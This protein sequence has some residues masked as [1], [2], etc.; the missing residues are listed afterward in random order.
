MDFIGNLSYVSNKIEN[1]IYIYL[2]KIQ[3]LCSFLK[4]VF[5]YLYDDYTKQDS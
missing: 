2:N 5:Y 4:K 3:S 1:I